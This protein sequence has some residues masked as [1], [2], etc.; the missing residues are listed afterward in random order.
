MAYALNGK[1]RSFD[2][3][4]IFRFYELSRSFNEPVIA[5]N[6]LNDFFNKRFF[7]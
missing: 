2:T 4:V 7:A 3:L 6:E 5:I 1:D